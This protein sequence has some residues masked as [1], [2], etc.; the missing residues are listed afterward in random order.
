[1]ETNII[2]FTWECASNEDKYFSFEVAAGSFSVDWGDGETR[3]YGM[4]RKA[5]G[6]YVMCGTFHLLHTYREGGTFAVTVVF[7]EDLAAK[8]DVRNRAVCFLGIPK[9]HQH[10]DNS[11]VTASDASK[12]GDIFFWMPAEYQYHHWDN[13]NVT[14]LD[15]SRCP[16]LMELY[17]SDNQL[18]TL[19]VSHNDALTN[20]D[21]GYNKITALDVSHNAALTDLCFSG[22]PLTTADVKLHSS[23]YKD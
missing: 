9:K 12:D 16:A 8:L 23:L 17:C 22:N 19:D 2:R 6:K 15:V 20:L 3:K 11:N 4:T 7:K 5:D 10:C 14:A 21:C 13:N 1:M 18:V